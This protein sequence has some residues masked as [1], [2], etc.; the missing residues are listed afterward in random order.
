MKIF[1]FGS[2]I[3]GVSY[4][5]L[6]ERVV[7]AGSGIMLLI[8]AIASIQGFILHNYAVIPYLTGF[9]L[10]NFLISVLVN[11]KLSPINV[12]AW[13]MVRKQQPLYIGAVQKRFAWT[14]GTLLSSVIFILSLY[15]QSN[16]SYFEIVC[17]L[18][19]VCILLLYLETAF[20]ICIGCKLYFLAIRLKLIKKPIEQPNCIG[21]A[22][23]VK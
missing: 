19:L 16:T 11:P 2:K 4:S 7:R 5:V 22:C 17:F 14:L 13:I 6:N 23:E 8:G 21:D 3:E 18:C 12:L 20:G 9:L 10:L 1:E 15:L